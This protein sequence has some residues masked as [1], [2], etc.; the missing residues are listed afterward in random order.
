MLFTLQESSTW[1]DREVT[2]TSPLD[3]QRYSAALNVHVHAYFH[4]VYSSVHYDVLV[5]G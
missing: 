1:A 4:V 2:F 5:S 3:R